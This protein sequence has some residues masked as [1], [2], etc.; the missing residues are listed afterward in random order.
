MR[1]YWDLG[2]ESSLG[3]SVF[4]KK[5]AVS[6]RVYKRAVS[7]RRIIYSAYQHFWQVLVDLR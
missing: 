7:T 3:A 4:S 1:A 6:T 5:R 2:A